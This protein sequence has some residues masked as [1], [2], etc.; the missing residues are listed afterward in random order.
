MSVKSF[1]GTYEILPLKLD[2]VTL[3][4]VFHLMVTTG[5]VQE[6]ECDPKSS[7]IVVIVLDEVDGPSWIVK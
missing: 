7:F 4:S 6:Y 2:L 5:F 3:P 1:H